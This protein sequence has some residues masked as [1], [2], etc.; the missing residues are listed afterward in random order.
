MTMNNLPNISLNFSLPKYGFI[1]KADIN[2]SLF[3]PKLKEDCG[4]DLQSVIIPLIT[5]LVRM[6]IKRLERSKEI[7]ALTNEQELE[8]EKLKTW[9]K[10]TN[11]E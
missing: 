1:W 6:M 11:H 10:E 9:L 7:T 2:F 3:L 5:K 8:L 4:V